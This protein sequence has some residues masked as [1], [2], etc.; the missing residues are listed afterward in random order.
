MKQT[1]SG[2]TCEKR[3]VYG[4][5]ARCGRCIRGCKS[6]RR[7]RQCRSSAVVGQSP[8]L[9]PHPDPLPRRG[10]G[11][12]ARAVVGV[13]RLFVRRV[14]GSPLLGLP[15]PLGGE[16]WG[17]GASPGYFAPLQP[18]LFASLGTR[19]DPRRRVCGERAVGRRNSLLSTSAR[20][21]S[22]RPPGK[23]FPVRPS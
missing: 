19:G 2:E 1:R 5:V 21:R 22:Q 7:L 16:G 8:A 17:E 4:F 20:T 12:F 11:N 10:R 3:P 18:T 9:P 23:L 6:V 15:L 13:H 14:H